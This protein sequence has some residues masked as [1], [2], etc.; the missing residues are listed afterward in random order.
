MRG[1]YLALDV[2]GH[3]PPEWTPGFA[4]SPWTYLQSEG[5][6]VSVSVYT[7]TQEGPPDP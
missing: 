5:L 7:H 1:L 2:W 6:W 3:G 4:A